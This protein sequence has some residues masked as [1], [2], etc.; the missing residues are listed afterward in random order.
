VSVV[1][2]TFVAD[3]TDRSGPVDVSAMTH[4]DHEHDETIVVHLVDDPVVTDP[5]PVG[6]VLALEGHTPRWTRLV[7]QQ[8]NRCSDPLLLASG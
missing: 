1:R 2:D 6:A 4:A 3:C 5:N 8:V 7:R